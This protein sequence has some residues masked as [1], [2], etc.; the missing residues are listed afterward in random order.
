ME[1][2][3]DKLYQQE[4]LKILYNKGFKKG[5]VIYFQNVKS[6]LSTLVCFIHTSLDFLKA[7]YHF[8]YR[9]QKNLISPDELEKT[10]QNQG[11]G[12]KFFRTDEKYIY[13]MITRVP[14][15][16]QQR[17]CSEDNQN[18]VAQYYQRKERLP[19]KMPYRQLSIQP[20]RILNLGSGSIPEKKLQAINVDTSNEGEPDY[21][22]DVEKLHIFSDDYFVI[23]RA[24]HI[25]E[26]FPP[27]KMKTV[28]KE[29][30][31]VLHQNGELHIAVPNARIVLDELIKG[32]TKHNQNSFSLDKTTAPLAQIYGIGYER[33]NTELRWRHK[34][35]FNFELLSFYL[36]SAGLDHIEVMDKKEDLSAINGVDDDSQNHY[37]LLVRARKRLT[38]HPPIKITPLNT[39]QSTIKRFHK[40][41]FTKTPPSLSIITPIRNEENN[42]TYFLKSI[43]Q[44][45]LL[46][47]PWVNKEHIFVLNGSIDNSR[48]LLEKFIEQHD[49]KNYQIIESKV[50]ILNA[51]QRG[52]EKRKFHGFIAKI[53]ADIFIP[54]QSLMLM[55]LFLIDQQ[56][57]QVT[58][59]ETIPVGRVNFFN[60]ADHRQC[61][62]TKRLYLHGRASMYRSDPFKLFN[63]NI[64]NDSEVLVEDIIFSFAY[65]MHYGFD[66]IQNTPGGFIYAPAIN[67]LQDLYNQ[68]DR[69]NH[70]MNKI[71][72]TLPYLKILNY[73]LERQWIPSRESEPILRLLTKKIFNS[74]PSMDWTRIESSKRFLEEIM[75]I[76]DNVYSNKFLGGYRKSDGA[77]W[78]FYLT[79]INSLACLAENLL[80]TAV[81]AF[82]IPWGAEDKIIAIK[83]N[84]GW[85]IP[86]GHLEEG[87]NII[88]ALNREI[89][90]E[91][92]VSI[93]DIIPFALLETDLDPHQKT[94]ILVFK[95][96]GIADEFVKTEEISDRN[97][98]FINDFVDKYYGNKQLISELI[99]IVF[100]VSAI[101]N[102]SYF[103]Q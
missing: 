1:I 85:D 92:K 18:S 46:S 35:L 82:V 74:N 94:G 9:Q 95:A 26:H 28:I 57:V 100:P 66:S 33:Q 83:N 8:L 43:D 25:L 67:S 61:I 3:I 80:I 96:H 99:K 68:C 69:Q 90:E 98:F 77:P 7:Q 87:E 6:I 48:N 102:N 62:R 70:E 91:A 54:P 53:D 16:I 14:D 29:W 2:Q 17:F 39:L 65:I 12:F 86:G 11:Y 40:T 50:G 10:L 88:E 51:F 63:K 27:W 44:I 13:Y 45:R 20:V 60:Y 52:I 24:S 97:I 21:V 93:S 47:S 103:V 101:K 72:S 58:Y 34:I 4:L 55:Y 78:Y 75:M 89:Q 64:L 38:A 42:L 31:R 36:K 84:R 32:K 56:Q 79:P 22:C 15:S 5:D 19:Y 49:E 41:N 23:V 59:S 81:V 73:L 37:T 30:T 76:T 71:F